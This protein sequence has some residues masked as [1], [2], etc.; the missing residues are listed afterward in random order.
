MCAVIAEFCTYVLDKL[1]PYWYVYE[2]LVALQL[3][4]VF[5]ILNQQGN[6]I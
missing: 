6:I 2:I 4:Y 3:I 1:Q 5:F